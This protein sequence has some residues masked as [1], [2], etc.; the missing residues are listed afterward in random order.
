MLN[1]PS[2]TTDEIISFLY[3]YK[4]AG[5]HEQANSAN[6]LYKKGL[7]VILLTGDRL[8]SLYARLINQP[9]IYIHDGNYDM[10]RYLQEVSQEQK[11]EQAKKLL[12]TRRAFILAEI[13]KVKPDIIKRLTG[14]EEDIKSITHLTDTFEDQLYAYIFASLLEKIN[15]LKEK[16]KAYADAQTKILVDIAKLIPSEDAANVEA[17]IKELNEKY[18]KF[19]KEQKELFDFSLYPDDD[20]KEKKKEKFNSTALD[21]DNKLVKNILNYFNQ[22]TKKNI[23]GMI[24]REYVTIMQGHSGPT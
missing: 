15:K 17:T 20:L 11:N 21:Y 8:C 13:G 16:R 12:E 1:E 14:L 7:N 10:Y 2:I 5:D 22:F 24:I 3:D 6:Y 4:R 18:D 23:V 19:Y 9:C